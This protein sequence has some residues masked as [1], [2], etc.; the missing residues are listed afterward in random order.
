MQYS[1]CF[2]RIINVFKF[3]KFLFLRTFSLNMIKYVLKLELN[4]LKNLNTK[5]LSSI[6]LKSF[7]FDLMTIIFEVK[8][9]IDF[10]LI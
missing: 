4:I 7:Y 1:S 6:I 8:I 10:S 2:K 3:N 9:L 5:S